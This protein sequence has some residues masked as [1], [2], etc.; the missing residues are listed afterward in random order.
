MISTILE[1]RDVSFRRGS[2]LLLD[3]LSFGIERNDMVV[4]F[5]GV[6]CVG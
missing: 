4:S 5:A 1:F 2:R 6:V 3:R